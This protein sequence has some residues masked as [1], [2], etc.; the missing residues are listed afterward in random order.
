[1]KKKIGELTYREITE[2]CRNNKKCESCPLHLAI[3]KEE[4]LCIPM[5]YWPK[6][7]SKK[8]LNKEIEV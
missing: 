3:Y 5:D 6:A 2:I 1:M 4:N 7:V 8:I